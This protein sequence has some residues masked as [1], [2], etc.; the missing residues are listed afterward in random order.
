MRV[1]IGTFS[2]AEPGGTESYVFTVAHEL[3]RLGHH[4]VITA[5]EL[6][7]MADFAERHG[8]DVARD[9]RE[10]PPG[11]DAILANDGISAA[12]LAERYPGTRLVFFAH[13]DRFDHQLPP[14]L[15]DVVSTVVA[16]SDIVA[17]RI[18]AL[19]LDVPVVR[20]RHPIDTERFEAAG[21]IRQ[22]P[23][24]ALL[25][26]NYLDGERVEALVSAW[27]NAGVECARVGLPVEAQLDVVPAIGDADVV[28][29]KARAALEGMS[30]AR[31]VYVFDEFGGDGW[32][33]PDSYEALEANNFAGQASPRPRGP[34]ELAADLADYAPDMGW[35]NRELI[36]THHG[37]R[38]HAMKLVEVLRGP[39]PQPPEAVTAQGEIARLTRMNWN[40]ERRTMVLQQEVVALRTCIA[41][42]EAEAAHAEDKAA[43]ALQLLG[44]RRARIGL[45]LG[46]ALDRLRGHR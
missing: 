3:R 42:A 36:R 28:V 26:S 29:G 8:I 33:T 7:A 6:G 24:R 15:P 46:R 21:P 25:L 45:A 4:P 13:S 9:P 38:K 27:G 35:M 40:A 2:F 32:V 17:D 39:E 18:Q 12:S 37:A 22:R 34:D 10:L 43:W 23:L 44:T 31:A 19:A 16:A 41:Q 5:E 1:V 14:L 30:C 20:L 11:C